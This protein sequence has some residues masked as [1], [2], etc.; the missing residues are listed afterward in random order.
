MSAAE[1]AKLAAK[2]AEDVYQKYVSQNAAQS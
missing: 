2:N 1:E